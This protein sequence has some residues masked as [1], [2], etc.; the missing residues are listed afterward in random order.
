[1]MASSL[2][3]Q[4]QESPGFSR[5]EDVKYPPNWEEMGSSEKDLWE[6]RQLAALRG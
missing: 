2:P 4:A 5:G 3:G 1:M 6:E